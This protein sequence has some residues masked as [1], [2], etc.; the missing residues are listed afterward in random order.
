MCFVSRMRLFNARCTIFLIRSAILIFKLNVIKTGEKDEKLLTGIA[1][2][3][4]RT[5]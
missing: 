2:F 1:F 4:T 5:N 3:L